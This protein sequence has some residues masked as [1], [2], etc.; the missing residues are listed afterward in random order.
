MG[1]YRDKIEWEYQ[2]FEEYP[3]DDRDL[4]KNHM[5]DFVKALDEVTDLS[6]Y[7]KL[8]QYLRAEYDI[9]SSEISEVFKRFMG[10]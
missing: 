1:Y 4:I 10:H 7:P 9:G 5:S 3:A 8:I 6:E 2:S